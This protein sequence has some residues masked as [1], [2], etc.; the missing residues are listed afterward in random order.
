MS[1]DPHMPE[2][3]AQNDT[4]LPNDQ[5]AEVSDETPKVP[6]PP[7]TPEQRAR[8]EQRIRERKERWDARRAERRAAGRVLP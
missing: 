6:R 7:I 5:G 4:S 2:L 8:H 3:P 1:H